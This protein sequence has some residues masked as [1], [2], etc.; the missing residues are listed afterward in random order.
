MKNNK[1]KLLLLLTFLLFLSKERCNG[2]PSVC[3]N[4]GVKYANPKLKRTFLTQKNN[5]SKTQLSKKMNTTAGVEITHEDFQDHMALDKERKLYLRAT[6]TMD[7]GAINSGVK[8]NWIIPDLSIAG[9][10]DIFHIEPETTGLLDAFPSDVTH[11][12]YTVFNDRY[13]LYSLTDFDLFFYGYAENENGVREPVDYYQTL[14]PVPLKLGEEI[15]SIVTFEYDNDIALDSIQYTDIYTVI[16]EGTLQSNDGK[17]TDAIKV[18]YTEETREYK[19]G[20]LIDESSRDEIVFYS[21]SGQYIRARIEDAWNSEGV[22]NLADFTYQTINSKATLSLNKISEDEVVV[23]PN[24]IYSDDKLKIQLP[25]G[26]SVCCFELYN[27]LGKKISELTVSNLQ[28]SSPF[29]M[30][31]PNNIPKG[32]YLY[33][34]YDET[35]QLLKTGKLSVL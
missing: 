32:L 1:L 31:I 25:K 34:V 21:K 3:G 16:G 27:T 19:G 11:A 26:K 29:E 10:S 9:V 13:D 15:Q 23:Y 17:K 4:T 24:P 35:K 20:L 18:I 7:I 6:A 33:R 14:S 8:E 12:F 22:V 30:K 5:Q 2:A 28:N